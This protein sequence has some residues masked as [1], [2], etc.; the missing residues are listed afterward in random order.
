MNP[1]DEFLTVYES[2]SKEMIS[3]VKPLMTDKKCASAV[4]QLLN[5]DSNIHLTMELIKKA[6]TIQDAKEKISLSGDEMMLIRYFLESLRNQ[7]PTQVAILCKQTEE[8]ETLI[9]QL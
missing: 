5:C 2:F 8:L 9:N 3:F 1:I 4:A 7:D 6:E